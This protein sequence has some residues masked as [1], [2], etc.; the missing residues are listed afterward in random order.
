V[1]IYPQRY[2]TQDQ[3]AIR[4]GPPG[5]RAP[6]KASSI[7][8]AFCGQPK[9]VYRGFAPS[10]LGSV[11]SF[12][13]GPE[14][15]SNAKVES[16]SDRGGMDVKVN[17]T[18]SLDFATS[19]PSDFLPDGIQVILSVDF[20]NDAETTATV[21]ART[22]TPT[23]LIFTVGA[24]P[25]TLDL[26]SLSA[27]EPFVPGSLT[28]AV[29]L[30][31]FGPA[32][33]TDN[34]DGTLAVGSALP[35]G[36]TVDYDAGTLTGITPALT[37]LSAV[38]A[39][40]TREVTK[41][42]VLLCVVTG[43]PGAPVV[44]SNA[45][46]NR[47]VPIAYPS[48]PYGYMPGASI[49]ALEAAVAILNEVAAARTDLQGTAWPNLK[50][51]LDYDLG[52]EAMGRRLGRISRA[53]RSN[54]YQA[55][56]GVTEISVGGSLSEVN[57][58]F[59]P[60]ITLNG[61]GSESQTGA[62][63]DPVDTVRNVCVV[64]DAS[65]G[66]RLIDNAT[67]RNVVFG[68][69]VQEADFILD[70]QITFQSALT[71]V[72]GDADTRFTIQLAAGDTLQGPDGKFYEV[73]SITDDAAL[74][75]RDAYQGGSDTSG[76]LI[77]RRF[78]L[79]FRKLSAGVESAHTIASTTQVQFFLPTFL[80]HA[81]AA[82]DAGTFA[83]KPGE[84]P[85]I[86]DATTSVQGKIALAN[87][88][89]PY[90]GSINLQVGG[91]PVAGGPFHTLN[92][93]GASGA[94]VQ[95]SPGVIDVTNIGPIGPVGPGGGPGPAGPTGPQGISINMPSRT[96]F[97]VAGSETVAS[98]P[99]PVA[100]SHTVNFGYN[101]R[102]LSGG[103]ALHRDQGIFITPN[104]RLEITLIDITGAQTGTI[105][106]TLGVTALPC[107]CVGKLYLNACGSP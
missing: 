23:V 56:A 87:A 13:V 80:T 91:V 73:L 25:A 52:S 27:L 31:G 54:Q 75:L 82:F 49:E 21:V 33:I 88:G 34:G 101:V 93:T 83:Y 103:F 81:T 6:Y 66:D 89:S 41:S 26:S 14:G 8:Q 106:G 85:V 29:D 50:A 71:A 12:A 39:T 4:T 86:P 53:I 47:D 78:K 62:V 104:D 61:L 24:T 45:P 2:F 10:V 68:R 1:A 3:V 32:T 40:Y 102:F 38:N 79:R 72:T 28:I 65:T 70:G 98:G 63:A 96:A 7:N 16:S 44:A 60:E 67:D 107:D 35:M 84:R 97:N 36:G 100:I 11:V 99:G 57:R 30:D 15:Y 76:A 90:V 42:E 95:T 94:L 37:A 105:V 9:G 48:V 5:L 18:I 58:D 74:T 43:T 20:K 69:L 55:A 22:K 17:S 77:R 46:T 92:F 19:A 64:L 59:L 51:R